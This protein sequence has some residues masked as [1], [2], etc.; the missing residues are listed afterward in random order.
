MSDVR[1]GQCNSVT[2]EPLGLPV[3][4]RQA[5]P[6]CGS[7]SRRFSKLAEGELKL[8]SKR[9]I[10]GRRGGIRKWFIEI[11]TGADWSTRFQKFMNKLRLI[12]RDKDFYEEK[13]HD[14][15]TGDVIHHV[16]GPLSK[17]TGHGSDKDS[18]SM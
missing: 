18:K 10:R 3:E 8:H 4:A 2:D 15:D 17:H 1:C 12:D 9:R 14:P 16:K 7:K 5:C 6:N 13:V 11:V